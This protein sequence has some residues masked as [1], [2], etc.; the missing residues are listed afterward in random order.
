MSLTVES[1]TARR[2]SSKTVGVAE[3]VP[4][5]RRIEIVKIRNPALQVAGCVLGWSDRDRR[6]AAGVIS[7]KASTAAKVCAPAAVAGVE[8]R[9]RKEKPDVSFV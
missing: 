4:E 3:R 1:E 8:R 5:A 7:R 2:S 9:Q 6:G